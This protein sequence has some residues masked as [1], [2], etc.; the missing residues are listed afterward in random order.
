VKPE[1]Q[2]FSSITISLILSR[3]A[4]LVADQFSGVACLVF[5]FM[6]ILWKGHDVICV[7]AEDLAGGMHPHPNL[8][9]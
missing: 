6:E 7:G 8:S 4:Y 5:S 3:F 9:Q 2:Q 1:G